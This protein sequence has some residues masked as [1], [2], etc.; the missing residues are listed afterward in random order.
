MNRL[1]QYKT[2]E[3]TVKGF[4]IV[5][6]KAF[7]NSYE[8]GGV[9]AVMFDSKGNIVLAVTP[10]GPAADGEVTTTNIVANVQGTKTDLNIYPVRSF[11]RDL[12]EVTRFVV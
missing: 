3:A 9:S 8:I 10:C 12:E 2:A 1:T 5:V 7:D 4:R 11:F 6:T